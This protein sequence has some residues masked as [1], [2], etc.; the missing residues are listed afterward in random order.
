M[1]VIDN[2]EGLTKIIFTHRLSSIK[3]CD[4]VVVMKNGAVVETGC[5]S[6]LLGSGGYF[7]SSISI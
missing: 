3:K 1:D 2:I 7:A 5:P 4:Q 6:V